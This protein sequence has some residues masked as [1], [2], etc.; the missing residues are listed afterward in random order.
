[1]D[2]REL[3]AA[4]KSEM[5]MA[6]A[7]AE[8]ARE[9]Y[10]QRA[11]YVAHNNLGYISRGKKII[12]KFSGKDVMA[13]F[14]QLKW[15]SYDLDDYIGPALYGRMLLKSG[16]PSKYTMALC[17][18]DMVR[19]GCVELLG[20]KTNTGKQQATRRASAAKSF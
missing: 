5:I 11:I 14:D 19:N 3:L 10:H 1:M 2:D 12:I 13:V 4:L 9:A 15:C 16:K 20:N 7:R 8:G 17:S 6:A 18:I